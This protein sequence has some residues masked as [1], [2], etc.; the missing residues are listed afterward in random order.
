MTEP[1]REFKLTEGA[2]RAGKPPGTL[3]V[4]LLGLSLHLLLA[5]GCGG[6]GGAGGPADAVPVGEYG[7]LT[8]ETATF[9]QSTHEGITLAAEEI[10]A[11]GGVKG[12]PVHLYTEDDQSKPE[13]AA[14]VVA[15]LIN[16]NRVLGILGEVA[17]SRSLAAAPKAQAAGIPMITPAS[18]NPKVTLV[19]DYIFRACFTDDFQGRVMAVFLRKNLGVKKAAILRD[20]RNDY[21]VGLANFFAQEFQRLGGTIAPDV[22]YSAGDADFK[23]QLTAIKA[24]AP[25][26]IFIPGYYPD[27]GQIAIQARDLGITVPMAGGDGWESPKL[28]EIGGKSLE[29][30]FYSTHFFAEDPNPT[31]ANFVGKYRTKYG[32][33]PDCYSALGYEAMMLLADAMNRAPELTGR[34]IRD[35]LAS[36]SGFVGVTGKITMDANRNPVKSAI[37]L[38]VKGGTMVY[39]GTITP[40]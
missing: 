24:A 31:V 14:T 1:R 39:H 2:R 16:Q 7:S 5:T 30:C 25:E 28:L 3:L 38:E 15:K 33:T 4:A 17:S 18:T 32:R 23:A 22:S 11:T 10:N 37:V 19:G 9:G 8:G 12:K 34:A 21:S 6:T 35:A 13:E 36:T 29:G 20:I 40:E 27:V 26:A